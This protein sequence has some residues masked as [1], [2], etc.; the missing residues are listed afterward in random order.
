MGNGDIGTV[1]TNEVAL[2]EAY[3]K[4]WED[5]VNER[6]DTYNEYWYAMF[7]RKFTE[8]LNQNNITWEEWLHGERQ[9][10]EE[11]WAKARNK[12]REEAILVV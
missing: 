3:M 5:A 4:G 12:V 10:A 7:E 1:T 8:W 9:R 2:Q 11:A 6:D